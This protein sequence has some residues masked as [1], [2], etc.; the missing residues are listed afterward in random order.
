MVRDFLLREGENCMA[1]FILKNTLSDHGGVTRGVCKIDAQNNLIEIIETKNIIKTADGAKTNEKFI[2]SDSLVSMNMW[3]FTPEFLK[4]L[5]Q[6]FEEFFE[7]TMPQNP[8]NAEYLIPS[9]IGELLSEDKIAVKVLLTADTWYGMTYKE[10]VE[11]VKRHFR[12]ML[13][14]G[15]YK[16]DL[17]ADL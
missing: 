11:F 13:E 7:Q 10:D 5:E 14:E 4:Q 9:F 2:D 17:F 12:N 16:K 8:L 1:G 15:T 6:G 3:G